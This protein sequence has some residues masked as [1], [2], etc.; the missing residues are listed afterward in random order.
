[1]KYL[2]KLYEFPDIIDRSKITDYNIIEKKLSCFS[3]LKVDLLTIAIGPE[4]HDLRLLDRKNQNII[5]RISF[6]VACHHIENITIE[7]KSMNVKLYQLMEKEL[8]F[9]LKF[10][11]VIIIYIGYTSRK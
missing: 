11:K 5:G 1:M 2:Q 3:S 4:H 8:A 10:K 9:K 7:F 6:N